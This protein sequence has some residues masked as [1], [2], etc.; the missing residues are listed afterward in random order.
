MT[1][2]VSATEKRRHPHLE[3]FGLKT[4]EPCQNNLI[5]AIINYLTVWRVFV[6]LPQTV[7]SSKTPPLS[8]PLDANFP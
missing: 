2:S 4:S 6:T 1:V 3:S 8:P 7:P 5:R